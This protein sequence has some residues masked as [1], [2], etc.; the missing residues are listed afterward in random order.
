MMQNKITGHLVH[1]QVSGHPP[2]TN[3]G[4]SWEQP[5]YPLAHLIHATLPAEGGNQGK[6]EPGVG[7]HLLQWSVFSVS[8]TGFR[9]T[10]EGVS[11]EV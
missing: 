8:L 4:I 10:V 9:I 6:P 11:R 2:R 1:P 3:T 5:L 7:S